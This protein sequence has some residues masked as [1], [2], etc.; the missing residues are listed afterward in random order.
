[1]KKTLALTTIFMLSI[2]CSSSK[3]SSESVDE[4]ALLMGV[5]TSPKAQNAQALEQLLQNGDASAEGI[6]TSPSKDGI[7]TSPSTFGIGTSP[8]KFGIGTSP[9]KFG[10]ATSP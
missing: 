9:S 10:V 3:G 5:A 8:S 4:A 7:G 2:S 1:M 6:G